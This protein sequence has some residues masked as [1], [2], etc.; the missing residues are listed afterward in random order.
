MVTIYLIQKSLFLIPSRSKTEIKNLIVS[1]LKDFASL[2]LTIVAVLSVLGIFHMNGVP[3]TADAYFQFIL[4]VIKE[5]AIDLA[6]SPF[7][8]I[9]LIFPWRYY[10][11]IKDK[12]TLSFLGTIKLAIY[13]FF[14][15]VI[16]LPFL[17]MLVIE[18]CS[19]VQSGRAYR[20]IKQQ[21]LSREAIF[22]GMVR[23]ALLIVSMVLTIAIIFTVVRSFALFATFGRDKRKKQKKEIEYFNEICN[24]ALDTLLFPLVLFDA[25]LVIIPFY[26]LSQLDFNLVNFLS[27]SDSY[28]KTAKDM[29]EEVKNEAKDLFCLFLF[30]LSLLFI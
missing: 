1:G 19:V 21:K 28:R 8:I 30:A 18:L 15:G 3:K 22:K 11:Y 26:R 10:L 25:L 27:K 9:L 5:E 17:L 24:H 29:F 20:L 2:L 13:H 7:H 14:Q 23:L 4:K 16:D 6:K 12:S